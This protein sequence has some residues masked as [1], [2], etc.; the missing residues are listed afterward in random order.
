MKPSF[1]SARI[2][3]APIELYYPPIDGQHKNQYRIDTRMITN[4]QS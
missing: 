1:I 3:N 4:I 2:L